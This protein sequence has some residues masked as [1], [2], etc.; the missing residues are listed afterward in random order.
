MKIEDT[1]ANSHGES[2]GHN[3]GDQIDWITKYLDLADKIIAS[4]MPAH[5]KPGSKS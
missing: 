4:H 5:P 3:A 1:P 2:S